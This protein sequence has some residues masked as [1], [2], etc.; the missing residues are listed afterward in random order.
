MITFKKST[1]TQKNKDSANVRQ[2]HLCAGRYPSHATPWNTKMVL[3]SVNQEK[4]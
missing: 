2:P 4:A 1:G 3:P